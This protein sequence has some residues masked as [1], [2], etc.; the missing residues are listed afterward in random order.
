MTKPVSR[1]LSWMAGTVV[2]IG[3]ALGMFAAIYAQTVVMGF[4]AAASIMGAALRMYVGK[5]EPPAP[6]VAA[7]GSR[8][9]R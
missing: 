8:I 6:Y 7:G 1:I 2:V 4:G 9:I 3:L 5:H